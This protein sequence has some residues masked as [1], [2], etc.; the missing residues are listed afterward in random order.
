MR[1]D[2]SEDS[3]R[4]A[5][6]LAASR[7][8]LTGIARAPIAPIALLVLV[9]GLA[10]APNA[11]GPVPTPSSPDPASTPSGA[12]TA[13]DSPAALSRCVVLGASASGGFGLVDREGG[14]I[15]FARVL[16]RLLGGKA[17]PPID[18][19]AQMFFLAPERH[20]RRLVEEALA[21]EPTVVVAVD[22]LFWFGYG[23]V[24]R[25][26]DRF[27]L[28]E[29]GLELLD[30][31]A[32]P[33]V[34]GGIPDMRAAVG[35][36]LAPGQVPAPETLRQLNERIETF[37]AERPR[38]VV[39]PV[40][41]FLEDLAA[42]RPVEVAGTVWGPG[43]RGELLQ[44]DRLHPTVEGLVVLGQLVLQSVGDV[45]GGLEPAPGAGSGP[46]DIAASLVNPTAS[47]PSTRTR[48]D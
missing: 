40:V 26:T 7:P 5:D 11:C 17:E 19:A 24:P 46:A 15:D 34:I 38:F 1:I 42:D 9:V 4:R 3:F 29:T 18:K 41:A 32:C 45:L 13:P 35:T 30:R 48:R 36:M 14:S 43:S 25:E 2:D 12:A 16:E 6:P 28:L 37:A 23:L 22:F 21:A 39:A 47:P 20:G 33:V 31:F 44:A 10:V 27:V 8:R